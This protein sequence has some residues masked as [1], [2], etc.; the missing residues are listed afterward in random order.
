M[1]YLISNLSRLLRENVC[2]INA[3]EYESYEYCCCSY[4]DVSVICTCVS[5]SYCPAR[6]HRVIVL[7]VLFPLICINHIRIIPLVYIIVKTQRQKS[8]RSLAWHGLYTEFTRIYT[9]FT[10]DCEFVWLFVWSLCEL[11]VSWCKRLCEKFHDWCWARVEVRVRGKIIGGK[12][13]AQARVEVRVDT[14]THTS[15][16]TG[17]ARTLH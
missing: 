16:H 6:E 2:K 8:L 17:P 5:W 4:V 15:P 10:E 12:V 3:N 9:S 14:S 11:C 7:S 13:C 1:W